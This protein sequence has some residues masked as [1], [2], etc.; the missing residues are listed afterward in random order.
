MEP[1]QKLSVQ[2][3][4]ITGLFV[5]KIDVHDDER[6]WFKENWNRERMT[7]SGLPDL[8]PVQNNISF[9]R[10]RG[11]TRGFHAE[12]WDK[13]I[14]VGSGSVF[15]AWVDLRSGEGFGKTFSTVIEPGIAVFVPRGVA[16][17]FQTLEDNTV[18]TYLVNDHWSSESKYV[19][20]NLADPSL[21]INWPI[22][23]A[24]A[25]ISKKDLGNPALADVR[26]F[27]PKKALIIGSGGQLGTA[28]RAIMP[29]AET[30]DLPDFNIAIPEH[31]S[32][33]IWKDFEVV[34]NASAFTNVDAA[35]TIDGRRESWATNAH[36]VAELAKLAI[37]HRFTL[38]QVSTD[39]VFDGEDP[40][41]DENHRFSPLN[42]YGA[43]KAAGDLVVSLV[44]SHYII[45]TSWLVGDG[46]NFF[47][48]MLDLAVKGENPSVVD[49]QFGRITHAKDLAAA[50]KYLL[51]EKAPFGT[52]NVTSGGEVTTWFELARKVFAE[53]GHD[54]NR[55]KPVSTDEYLSKNVTAAP[56]PKRSI[57]K[58]SMGK[59]IQRLQ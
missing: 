47:T 57:L 7:G 20:V 1:A 30:L 13:Y 27:S 19:N 28:L 25:V 3:T 14:S 26:P 46:N 34:I 24:D 38:V 48:K 53:N 39:Y 4:P 42:V 21:E 40:D 55:V 36:G 12:P 56:R 23:L 58:N 11:T 29:N 31:L 22:K 33:I 15:G 16:N 5:V 50:I 17:A 45:R 2:Q 18:Y 35:E 43:S 51:E 32:A 8:G 41:Y 10:D 44:P 52:Y 54:A 49:D 37:Q 59:F 9:N 6:G